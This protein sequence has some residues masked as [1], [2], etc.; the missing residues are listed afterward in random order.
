M[1]YKAL[2]KLNSRTI[3]SPR[4]VK[5]SRRKL[6]A[7]ERLLLLYIFLGQIN[8]SDSEVNSRRFTHGLGRSLGSNRR[9]D[10]VIV[11]SAEEP[12]EYMRDACMLVCWD[13]SNDD[14]HTFE[15]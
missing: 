7:A 4:S 10:R 5:Q 1:F 11:A 15:T 13:G 6:L 12:P 14:H 2:E 9:K 3:Q 8:L